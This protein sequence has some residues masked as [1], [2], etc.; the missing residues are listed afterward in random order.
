LHYA[1]F[2]HL[3]HL[4]TFIF[5]SICALLRAQN[6]YIVHIT[7]LHI[8]EGYSEYASNGITDSPTRVD[9][10]EP[11]KRLRQSVE[12]INRLSD[13]LTIVLVVVSGD[14]TDSGELS[15][16]VAARDAL[17]K[18][19]VPYLPVIGNHDMWPYTRSEQMKMCRGDS[20]F[21]SVFSQHLPNPSAPVSGMYL[22]NYSTDAGD[23]RFLSCDFGTRTPARQNLPG[24][25]P[26]ADLHAMPGGTLDW[27]QAQLMKAA[28][29]S[30]QVYIV[31]HWPLIREPIVNPILENFTFTPGEYS[32]LT[33]ML[34]RYRLNI[35]AWLC[36]HL[37]RNHVQ[38][39]YRPGEADEIAPCIETTANK[40]YEGGAFRLV[41]LEN[42]LLSWI[43]KAGECRPA[44]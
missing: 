40:K 39:I 17:N 5:L 13:S 27:L 2:G 16:F 32:I 38:L 36:G 10:D 15:E 28:S 24:V 43:C 26:M 22:Q 6:S 8:G 37:H 4:L 14:I 3:K 21:Y 31:S 29:E 11:L 44:N 23:F 1:T 34:Y 12:A 25:G 19:K 33:K 18:L 30:K 42:P 7:D 20:V 41:T 9:V 35:K